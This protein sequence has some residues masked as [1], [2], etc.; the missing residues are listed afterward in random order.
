[1][2]PEPVP[3]W[4]EGEEK[5]PIGVIPHHC[6]PGNEAWGDESSVANRLRTLLSEKKVPYDIN[7]A[8]N[9]VWLPSHTAFLQKRTVKIW[10]KPWLEY[11]NEKD[12][13]ETYAERAMKVSNRQ[14]HDRHIEYSGKVEK[15]LE[16][17]QNKLESGEEGKCPIC[18]EKYDS[19]HA[20]FG[21]IARLDMISIQHGA[22]L[23]GVYVG[24]RLSATMRRN[25]EAGYYTSQWVVNLFQ[26]VEG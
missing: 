12:F 16:A 10:P 6:I 4:L 5:R 8:N 26:R 15:C 2:K 13:Q 19:Q 7:H 11:K 3:I 24:E 25:V 14:F 9:G 17:L 20:P 21:L 18:K 23:C 22:L 1:M